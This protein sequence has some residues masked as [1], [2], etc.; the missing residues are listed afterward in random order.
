MDHRN[1]S[2][3]AWI[4]LFIYDRHQCGSSSCQKDVQLVSALHSSPRS[5][6][7]MRS[8][9]FLIAFFMGGLSY[10]AMCYA[11][12]MPE[13]VPVSYRD[14]FSPTWEA[15]GKSHGYVLAAVIHITSSDY[16][17]TSQ[18]KRKSGLVDHLDTAISST[19][20]MDWTTRSE[21]PLEMVWK[22]PRSRLR[23]SMRKKRSLQTS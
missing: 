12:G 16:L 11:F 1:C 4:G 10:I 17:A 3:L 20:Q 8:S 21:C 23:L 14:E 22:R 18:M 2:S 15:L 19:P 7:L 6:L 13:I 5:I 9:G